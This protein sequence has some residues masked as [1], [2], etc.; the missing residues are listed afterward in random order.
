[1][2]IQYDEKNDILYISISNMNNSYGED[3]GDGNVVF[4]DVS[5]EQISGVTI[6]DFTNKTVRG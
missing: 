4:R 5:T 2:K 3:D 1:M 6:F